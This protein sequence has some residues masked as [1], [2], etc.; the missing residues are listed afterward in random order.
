MVVGLPLGR[1][2]GGLLEVPGCPLGPGDATVALVRR[3][4]APV[5]SDRCCR[6]A[7]LVTRSVPASRPG[8]RP[9]DGA[10]KT[11][12]DGAVPAVPPA[13]GARATPWK[14]PLKRSRRPRNFRAGISRGWG[15]Q[16][17]VWLRDLSGAPK[18]WAASTEA[19]PSVSLSRLVCKPNASPRVGQ[20]T[21]HRVPIHTVQTQ[22]RA[23]CTPSPRPAKEQSAH[24]SAEG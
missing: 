13:V 20:P 22:H 12:L 18:G 4:Q 5:R 7:E 10:P 2:G 8:E 3:R 17:S 19:T 21:L 15:F 6:G 24:T 11:A 14:G 16:T 1:S 23:R 9:G